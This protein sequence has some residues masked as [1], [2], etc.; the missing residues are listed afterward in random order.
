LQVSARNTVTITGAALQVQ[1]PKHVRWLSNKGP[2]WRA[3]RRPSGAI[4]TDELNWKFDDEATPFAND[5]LSTAPVSLKEYVKNKQPTLKLDPEDGAGI[6]VTKLKS[7]FPHAYP[8]L[9]TNELLITRRD[10]RLLYNLVL[11]RMGVLSELPASPALTP[12]EATI[13]VSKE[14][15]RIAIVEGNPG[16]GKSYSLLYPLRLLLLNNK[17]VCYHYCKQSMLFAFRPIFHGQ[18]CP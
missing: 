2:N 4:I 18:R 17:V 3:Y 7:P 1:A 12:T 13:Q 15:I 6:E 11:F 16:I 5:L 8:D 9:A 14:K 10:T